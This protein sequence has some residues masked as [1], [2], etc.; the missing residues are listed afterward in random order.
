MTALPKKKK[1]TPEDYL[2]LEDKAEFR[3]EY[4]DGII[5]AMV[6]GLLN[7]ARIIT[8]IDRLFGARLKKLVN[9]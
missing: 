7:H 9:R 8:N 1:Y 4:E 5:A 2:A 3:S 6:G